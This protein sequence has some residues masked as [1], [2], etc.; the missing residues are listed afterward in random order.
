M[1]SHLR[2]KVDVQHISKIIYIF[3]VL[4]FCLDGTKKNIN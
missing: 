4:K 1:N 3:N 2:E